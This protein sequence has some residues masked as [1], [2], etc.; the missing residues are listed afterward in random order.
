MAKRP[1]AF[2]S[3]AITLGEF[4]RRA[5]YH[6]WAVGKHHGTQNLF[7]LGFDHY[8]GLRDGGGNFFN[9]G[10]PR[11]REK[12]PQHKWTK[13]R[14][15]CFDAK[16]VS[17]Y[18]PKEKDFYTT[19][20]FTHWA[21]DFLTKYE[22]SEKPFFLYLSYQ[23]PHDPLQA[24]E[25]DIDKFAGIYEKGYQQIAEARLKRQKESGLI[26]PGQP[27]PALDS[28]PWESLSDAVR[29]DQARRMQV[30]AAMIHCMDRNIGRLLTTLKAQ[31][32]L[33]NTLIFFA[34]D[35]GGSGENVDKG[36]GRIGDIDRW[37]SIGRD[38]ASVTNLPW[39]RWKNSSYQG[40]ICT[41]FIVSWPAGIKKRGFVRD[42]THFIDLMPTL[43][44]L[45]ETPFPKSHKNNSLSEL[46]G[47][48]IL[49]LF[50]GE[51]RQA[52]VYFWDW[53]GESA[54]REGKWKAVSINRKWAL[55]DMQQD[56]G[57]TQDLASMYPEIVKKLSRRHQRWLKNGGTPR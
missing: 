28:K 12:A 23:A 10:L 34:S 40:G 25:K 46:P 49:P 43:A 16:T 24:W 9:M 30:Y 22:K 53:K 29:K 26:F 35:N 52:P 37:S 32:K 11:P 15:W 44:E 14:T 8:W 51:K 56:P 39:R 27:V 20:Y 2:N 17:P 21:I 4:M 1:G 6:T 45:T 57:E 36:H 55:Y 13:R 5:G 3:K 19:D 54:I 50:K 33:D 41:P 42:T 38:W 31:S 18:T 48:S 47:K 7:E